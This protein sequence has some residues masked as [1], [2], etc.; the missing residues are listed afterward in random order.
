MCDLMTAQIALQ[1]A[2][3]IASHN[4]ANAQA[5]AQN[6]AYLQNAEN[7]RMAMLNDARAIN[8]RQDQE[9]MAAAQERFT[10]MIEAERLAAKQQVTAG[11]SG[12]AA[13]NNLNY[14]LN[15]IEREKLREV[16]TINTNLDFTTSQLASE[17]DALKYQFM[18]RVNSVQKGV[19]SDPLMAGLGIGLQAAGS[20]GAATGFGSTGTYKVGTG[21]VP[22]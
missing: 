16:Q 5:R 19:G 2:S 3:G 9:N 4:A 20:V 7:A 22:K 11:E 14:L 18:D 1:A 17:R 6:K 10:K 15:N 8:Q 12:V 21:I 13:G